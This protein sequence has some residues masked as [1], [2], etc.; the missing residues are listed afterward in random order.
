MPERKVAITLSERD[1]QVVEQAVLDRDGACALE[2]LAGVVK[3]QIDAALKSGC[4]PVFELPFGG[5]GS[6]QPPAGGHEKR[7]R[8]HGDG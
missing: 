2:F 3:P 7:D 5:G 4:R 8:G 6:P 1:L